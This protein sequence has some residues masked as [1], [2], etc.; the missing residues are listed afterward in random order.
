MV[1]LALMLLISVNVVDI[2]V[3]IIILITT[4]YSGIEYFVKN[5]DVFK[6]NR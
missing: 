3:W 5:K 1:G 2:I 6:E 4:V